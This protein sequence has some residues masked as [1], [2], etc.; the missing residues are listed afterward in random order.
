MPGQRGPRGRQAASVR[1]DV[2]WRRAKAVM[3]LAGG[4]GLL[5]VVFG[6]HSGSDFLR[7]NLLCVL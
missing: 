4:F 5:N 6:S 2:R 7:K 3:G 1:H